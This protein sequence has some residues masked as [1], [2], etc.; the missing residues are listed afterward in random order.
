MPKARPFLS[1]SSQA[2]CFHVVSRASGREYRLGEEEK[3]F[4]TKTL[5]AYAALLGVQVLTHCT[6]SNHFHILVRVPERPEE[7]E[8]GGGPSVGPSVEMLLVRLEAA[9]GA[10]QIKQTRQNL[11][12][13]EQNGALDLI[14]AWRQRQIGA[15]YSLSEYMKRVKQRF[16]RWY[17]KRTGRVG[18]FWE[19]RY[20]STIVQDEEKAL[21][22]MGTYIDLNPV[23]AGITDDPGRYRWSGYAE[24][25]SGKAAALEGIA[26]ITGATADRVLGCGL[27]EAAP[28]E[29]PAQRKQRLLRAL[30]HYRQ[31]LGL[32][33]RPRVRED[34]TVMRR[35]V[36]AQAQERLERESGVRREQLLKRVR[37]FTQGVILGSREFINGWFEAN[38]SWFG[39][40]SQTERKTGARRIA[41]DWKHLYNLR[42]LS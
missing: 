31:M 27:G 19:D 37:H 41:K 12:L 21:R 18:I 36:S 8:R 10:E 25:M 35:G 24:A 34:G 14:E 30:V 9:V 29:T 33:G 40:K 13:W 3:E 2:G 20:R 16:T 26:C 32:A 38:R 7:C 5:H 15:M 11:R 6:M 39:G 22:M 42:Q 23:R 1:A 17:N 4:F 28:M